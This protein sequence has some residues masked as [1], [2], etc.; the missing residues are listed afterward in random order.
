MSELLNHT[1]KLLRYGMSGFVFLATVALLDAPG[2]SESNV[3]YEMKTSADSWWPIIFLAVVIGVL[4]YTMSLT[5]VFELYVRLRNRVANMEK[6]QGKRGYPW[7]AHDGR[8]FRWRHRAE[9]QPEHDPGGLFAMQKGIDEWKS[10]VHLL[11]CSAWATAGAALIMVLQDGRDFWRCLYAF[12]AAAVFLGFAV[13][14]D[15]RAESLQ[16]ELASQ[17][18][19]GASTGTSKAA[20]TPG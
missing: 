20:R 8:D 15:C 10:H 2:E 5:I 14:H 1:N 3:L 13:L 6:R 4:I 18:K 19:N 7:N 11:F 17:W 9:K 12:G 16:Q